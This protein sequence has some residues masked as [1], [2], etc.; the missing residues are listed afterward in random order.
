MCVT[1]CRTSVLIFFCVNITICNPLIRLCINK[2][3]NEQTVFMTFTVACQLVLG[4]L[5]CFHVCVIV[6]VFLYSCSVYRA[7]SK[8]HCTQE[9]HIDRFCQSI[10]SIKQNVHKRIHFIHWR[11]PRYHLCLPRFLTTT[12]C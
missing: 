2:N 6:R 5:K 9:C 10:L 8:D 12:V 4:V 11:R 1:C 7:V 3:S